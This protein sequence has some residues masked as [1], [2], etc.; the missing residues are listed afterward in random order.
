MA[1]NSRGGMFRNRSFLAYFGMNL[2]SRSSYQVANVAIIWFV[3]VVT[4]SAL[5][6]AI[7][8]IADTVATVLATLPA[9]V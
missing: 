7:V 1:N 5:D 6:V 8:G 3:F 2:I 4:K 9:G